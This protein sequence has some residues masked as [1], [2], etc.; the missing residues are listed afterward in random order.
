MFHEDKAE[1]IENGKIIAT[2]RISN[3]LYKL[4]MNQ[5]CLVTKQIVD[6][7]ACVH[8]LHRIFGHRN[9]ES[10]K[11]MINECM[12]TG[13]KLKT[14]NCES[15]CEVCLQSKFPR[16]PFVKEKPKTSK[17]ILDLIHTDLCGPMRTLTHSKK[18]YI[19]TFIDDHSRYTKIYLLNKKSETREKMIDFITLMKNQKGIAPKR[20]NSDRGGEYINKIMKKYLDN[21]GIEYQ[22]TS[23][24]TPQLNG[25]AERKNRTLIEMVRCM[26][27]EA[28]LPREFWGEAVTT[29]NYL[30]NRLLTSSINKT[31]Y[32]LWYGKRPQVKNFAAFGSECYVKIQ[33]E[34]RTKLDDCSKLLI[35]MGFDEYNCN[36]YRCYDLITRKIVISRDVVFK[37]NQNKMNYDTEITF[38][39]Q[40]TNAD[41]IPLPD[42]ADEGLTSDESDSSSDGESAVDPNVTSTSTSSEVEP[43][44]RISTR[45][46]KGKPPNR[47]AYD[48]NF[49]VNALIEPKNLREV[50]DSPEKEK[51]TKAMQEEI[52]ALTKN[53]TWSLCELPSNRKAVGCKWIFK[54]KTNLNGEIDRYKARLV[55]QGFSQKFGEDYDEVFAPVVKQSTFRMPLSIASKEKLKVHQFDVKTAFLNGFIKEE[56]YM[57]QPPGFEV[58]GK[59]K[60]VC[61]MKRSL[62]GL[63]QAAK[64]WNDA[65]NETLISFGFKRSQSDSCLY[66]KRFKNGDWCLM[67]VYVD[68]ILVTATN[69][70]II[71]KVER[72][73]S[74]TFDI[75][76][77]GEVK[78][79]LGI[80]INSKNG[81]Y[82]INKKK[83]I[84]KIVK[85]FGLEEAKT[86]KIPL[87]S[88]YEKNQ[89]EN[90]DLLPSNA[91]YQKLI[92]CLLFVSLN[93]RPDISASIAILAQKISKPTKYDWN[94]LKRVVQY[95][96]G[97][98]NYQL[99]LAAR[100][101]SDLIGYADANWGESR[102][103]RKSNSGF[104]FMLN[105][106]VVSWCSKKQNCVALSSTEAEVIALAEATKEVIWI[107]QLLFEI[108]QEINIPITIYE[109]NQSCRHMI[110]NG[111]ASNR[112][113]HIDVRCHFV[114]DHIKEGLI[115]CLYCSSGEMIAD[116]LTKPL[117]RIKF[118]KFRSLMGVHD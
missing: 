74:S 90:K 61:L 11:R 25:V 108:G 32:E 113:K 70:D 8:E 9:I 76:N 21:N 43:F 46:T 14:C 2:A 37:V 28:N 45:S 53:E 22:F 35:L 58:I 110:L 78:Y 109:D 72:D 89:I 75:R 4:Q 93:S 85:G 5:V 31:P 36:I 114:K 18:R 17:Q 50:M 99:Y 103:D 100:D 16:K 13:I 27:N 105:G 49:Q 107:K 24:Y 44:I 41:D 38:K 83:Y 30:Q 104:V 84:N 117:Q 91:Q 26:L 112:T 15:Q 57:K 92:G 96:K 98:A 59:E 81:I 48:E 79:Y 51:W 60:Q 12:V 82:S 62:Y 1:L 52:D 88:G 34:K 87:D 6:K 111:N 63:K 77:L 73:I 95:L 115:N 56:I 116:I 10:I 68:D 42:N 7:K 80:E 101:K 97:T 20:F 29:A 67:L 94:E 66:F 64:C 55:A 69:I 33:N 3:G 118:E 71:K 23:P 19:L 47:F 86:S 40:Q 54:I 102:H 65:I 39:G 106:G